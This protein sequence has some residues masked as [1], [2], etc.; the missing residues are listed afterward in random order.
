MQNMQEAIGEGR[1]NSSNRGNGQKGPNGQRL[2][3]A[4]VALSM[5]S[6]G[7]ASRCVGRMSSTGPLQQQTT[8]ESDI[9]RQAV[10]AIESRDR[11]GLSRWEV[12][13]GGLGT[14]AH[15][16]E[17]DV[18]PRLPFDRE[19]PGK[20]SWIPDGHDPF[21]PDHTRLFDTTLTYHEESVHL[22]YPDLSEKGASALKD[23]ITETKVLLR[24]RAYREALEVAMV[25]GIS[26]WQVKGAEK[27]SEFYLNLES[28]TIRNLHYLIGVVAPE[29][30][31]AD[32]VLSRLGWWSEGNVQE[33]L[34]VRE[35]LLRQEK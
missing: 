25:P 27:L 16:N 35:R 21:R 11:P 26:D 28:T 20:S 1:K 7:F 9:H 31:D 33:F 10:L 24:V 17:T 8:P 15:N 3:V 2:A 30:V 5:A 34:D 29:Q 23:L 18:Q 32:V 6:F 4:A 13:G 14:E 12:N 19:M 22:G